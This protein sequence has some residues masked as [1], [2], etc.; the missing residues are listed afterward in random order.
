MHN[1]QIQFVFLS[2]KIILVLANGVDTDEM[3]HYAAF[4]QDQHCLPVFPVC[5][6]LH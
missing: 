6:A 5:T 4:C 1:F 3:S 2:V